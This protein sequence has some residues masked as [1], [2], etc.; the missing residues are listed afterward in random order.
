MKGVSGFAQDL[1]QNLNEFLFKPVLPVFTI[2][3]KERYPNNKVLET[4][5][6]GLQRRL[7]EEK[8]YVEDWF[9]EEYE[10]V[11]F[12]KMKV[13]C[14]LF[15]AKQDG[16]TV[17]ETK[18]DIQRRFFKNNMSTLFSMNGQV[19]GHYTSEFITR[20]LKY[21]LLKDYLLINVDCTKM[22]YEF[23]KDLFMASRD[24]LK[25]G[26][27]AEELRDY[28]RKKLTKSKLDEINKRRKDSI[29]LESEDTSEL[30]KSFAKN[31]SKDSDLFKLLQNTLKL[32]ER[33]KEKPEK[34]RHQIGLPKNRC[35][36]NPSAFQVFLSCEH[37]ANSPMPVPVGGEKTLRFETDVEDHYFDRTDNPGDL[38]VSIL[39]VKRTDSN[40]GNE[41]G[42]TKE[43]G[44]LLNIIKSSPDKGTIKITLNPDTDLRQG[45]EIEIEAS[46]KGVG[47]DFFR[48]LFS[49]KSSTLSRRKNLLPWK[50]K[51]LIT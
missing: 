42:N 16:K 15:K 2:D 46:L 44:E 30:I 20:G 39:R 23:R 49:L 37:K 25:N 17:K 35:H 43:P 9:S 29:G 18:G 47:E 21:N 4:T 12:G 33:A 45:D 10:D 32:E 6:Y 7:E 38:Q 51:V 22:K 40:G 28:L 8:D 31:L 5:V 3:T 1:N 26:A 19:H 48:K 34:S 50:R 14:Y 13:T 41:K 24:R 36:S 27:K 11:L